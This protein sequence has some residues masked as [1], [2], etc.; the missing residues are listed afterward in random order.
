MVKL[1]SDGW[2]YNEVTKDRSPSWKLYSRINDY[3]FILENGEERKLIDIINEYDVRSILD[4]GCGHS[5]SIRRILES[6]NRTD[7]KLV[8]YDPFIEGKDVRPEETFDM[9][10]CHNVLGGIEKE[11]V[12]AVIEDVLNYSNKIVVIKIP[13]GKELIE[14]FSNHIREAKGQEIVE[15]SIHH[16]SKYFVHISLSQFFVYFLLKKHEQ[17]NEEYGS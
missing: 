10:M 9:V 3:K 11:Y 1:W 16:V 13:T 7:I 2:D 8:G 15:S 17:T 4:Y 12:A 6:N 5:T 14:F